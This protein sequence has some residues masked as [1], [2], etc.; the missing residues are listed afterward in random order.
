MRRARIAAAAALIGAVWSGCART[1][2][3]G[4][5]PPEDGAAS[6]MISSS[7]SPAA[8]P[9]AHDAGT[10]APVEI[11]TAGDIACDG[12]AQAATADTIDHLM[13][14]QPVAAVL[15]LGDEAYASGL[16]SEF[17][18]YYA[19]AWGRPEILSISHPVPGNHEYATGTATGYFDYF[20][21]A[22][23]QTGL[24]GA[25]D[26]G[27]YSFDLGGWH[28]IALN[29]SDACRWVS[30]AAGSPQ[31]QWLVADLAAHPN[32]CTLAF[33]HH[34]RFQAGT[35]SGELAAAAPLWDALYDAGADVVLNGHEHGYQQLA[36]LDKDGQVDLA[37]GIRT[38][39]VGTGGGDYDTTFGGPRAGALETSLISTHGVLQLTLRADGYDWQFLATDGTRPPAA[40]G[41]AACH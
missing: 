28:F 4:A 15:E 38:F 19:P 35:T 3:P 41:S 18:A 40:S 34:P 17:Q 39:V 2:Q 16:L 30:C 33:W 26:Q 25:R 32:R 20:D 22:G 31:Q 11:V 14:G 37:H 24:A 13:A 7:S 29:S 23:A 8:P 21:G 9:P 12:C 5:R 27:Y 1:G 36:P 6:W 10:A